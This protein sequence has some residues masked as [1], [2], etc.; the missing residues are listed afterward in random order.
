L[1]ITGKGASVVNSRSFTL[2][3]AFV[4]FW[5]AAIFGFLYVPSLF[6]VFENNRS[7][8]VF[9]WSGVV[10][11]K[12]LS[13][14]EKET[15]IKVNVSYFEGND[16]L[17]VK[18]LATKGKGYDMIVP[19]DY[20]VAFFRQH[21]LLKK[22]DKTKLDFWSSIHPK[23]INHW[24]DPQNEYSV[25]AE[26]YV[27][28]L[29]INKNHFPD[30]LPRAS[31]KT[32]FEPSGKYRLGVLNDSKEFAGLAVKYRYGVLR[33]IDHAETNEIKN[34]L[35]KQ[36]ERVEAYT[37]FRGDFLLESGNCSVVLVPISAIWKTIVNNESVA[38]LLPEE[39]TFLGLENY[40]I[41]EGSTK[42]E[43]VYQ[44]MNYLFRLDVQKY[45]FEH[46]ILLS[47]RK[48]AHFVFEHP[49]LRECFERIG[50]E[51]GGAQLFEHLL[52]DEQVNDIWMA[53]KGL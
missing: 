49:I 10:D 31:L 3:V 2:H 20:A 22:I 16:E 12:V 45:N 14:F 23:F 50:S 42:E 30:G 26:W 21:G 5:I 33:S 8:N 34:L 15:G 37:D 44:F 9:M 48:D 13:D 53:V 19:S 38:F 28:G 35:M 1:F 40:A 11:P 39:G 17:I 46:R 18:V 24:F 51:P 29:G 36:K 6:R 27:L 7:I 47:T 4:V 43:L 52:T 41:L 25:P 32:I